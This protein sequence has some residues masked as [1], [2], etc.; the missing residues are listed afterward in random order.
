[1][2]SL[3]IIKFGCDCKSRDIYYM[4]RDCLSP[5]LNR[6]IGLFYFVDYSWQLYIAYVIHV[7]TMLLAVQFI[8]FRVMYSPNSIICILYTYEVYI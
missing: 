8:P 1:M 7:T 3:K 4:S 5:A 6:M 2:L